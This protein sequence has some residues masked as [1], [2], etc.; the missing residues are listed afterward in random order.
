MVAEA[1]VPGYIE[2]SCQ[3]IHGQKNGK[4]FLL[5]WHEWKM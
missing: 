2:T 5:R 4:D 1:Y 3:R